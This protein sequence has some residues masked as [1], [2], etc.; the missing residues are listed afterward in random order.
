M[1]GALR[2]RYLT[3][4]VLAW[5][6]GRLPA[7]SQTEREA[8]AAGDLWWDGELFSG[9]P[10]WDRLLRVEPAQLT[11]AEREFIAGPVNELCRLLDDWRINVELLDLPPEVWSFL[12]EHR[13]L[14]MIIPRE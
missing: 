4:P 3:A 8:L 9:D 14:G 6:R 12:R 1:L 7:M 2:R 5:A 11:I 13:F 10:D